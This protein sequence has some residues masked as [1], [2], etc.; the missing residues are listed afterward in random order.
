MSKT[1]PQPADDQCA[2]I[3]EL[4]M[5]RETAAFLTR[6]AALLRP[7]V[8]D[9]PAMLVQDALRTYEWIIRQQIDD[10]LVISIS[11]ET[12]AYLEGVDGPDD[13]ARALVRLVPADAVEQVRAVIADPPSAGEGR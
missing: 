7:E 1:K 5:D 13:V 2:W 12:K 6:L 3:V 8:D 10:R 4:T 11:A 9:P